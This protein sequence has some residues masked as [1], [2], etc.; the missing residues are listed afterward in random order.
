MSA[1]QSIC[2]FMPL[3]MRAPQTVRAG[4]ADAKNG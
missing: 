3:L 2:T 4:G 1:M